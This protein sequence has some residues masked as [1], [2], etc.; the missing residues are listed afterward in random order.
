M[1]ICRKIENLFSESWQHESGTVYVRR[2]VFKTKLVTLTTAELVNWLRQF[3][4]FVQATEN[5]SNVAAGIA[6]KCR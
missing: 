6:E 4:R 3:A 1:S 5:E 2:V